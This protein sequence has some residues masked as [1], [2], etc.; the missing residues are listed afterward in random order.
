MIIEEKDFR[1][2][3]NS[4][5]SIFF[6]LELLYKVKPRNGEPRLEF[7]NV[8][9]GIGLEAALKKVIQY[10]ISCKHNTVKLKEYLDEFKKEWQSLKQYLESFGTGS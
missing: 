5:H 3:P 2:I 7:K 9:Y 8:A 10:R 4:D 6:D 1:L